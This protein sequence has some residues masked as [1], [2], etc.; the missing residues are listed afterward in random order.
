MKIAI[1]GYARQGQSAAEYYSQDKN[2]EITVCDIKQDIEIPKNYQKK[3]GKTYLDNLDEFDLIVRSPSIHPKDIVKNNNEKILEKV[4]TTTNIFFEVCPTKNIIGV[5]GTK[6]KGT[7]ST[8][9]SKMLEKAGYR[10]HLGGN[11]GL[12]P[13]QLLKEN[14]KAQ[15]WVVLELANFQL[16][17]LKLSP[18]IAICLTFTPEHLDWHTNTNEY[19][20]AKKQLFRWQKKD[21]IAIYYSANNYSTQIA[22]ASNGKKIPYLKQPGAIVENDLVK[23]DGKIICQRNEIKLIG[24]HNLQNICAAVTAVWQITQDI[25]SIKSA[26]ESFSGLPHRI[27]FVKEINNIRFYNDSFATA[28]GA[29]I[30]A[31]N[32]IKENKVL[33]LG[34]YDRGMDLNEIIA[35]IRLHKNDISNFVL[36]G[37]TANLLKKEL[38]D[39]GFS[40]FTVVK[41]KEMK[42]I[43]KTAYSLAKPGEAVIFSPA[44]ASFD[45]FKDFEDRGNQFKNQVMYL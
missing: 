23:I 42:D 45:M 25:N 43:V 32:A 34:G 21:E 29:T 13:L 27:E 2:N 40:N 36:I 24:D 10:V 18:R 30:A 12:D 16:I 39:N 17:D 8:L 19:L 31:I 37:S 33:I 22:S 26:I 1:L 28:Q 44:F 41:S 15:D 20:Q 7:T 3:L 38:S 5:T 4:T 6:G 11:I 9:I 14:I 35:E